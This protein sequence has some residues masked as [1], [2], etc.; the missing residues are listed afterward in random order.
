MKPVKQG[1]TLE[2]AEPET[3]L[4]SSPERWGNELL[5]G[6]VMSAQRHGTYITYR[7][8]SSLP[9]LLYIFN[10]YICL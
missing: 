10:I 6:F 5:R 1:V 9:F 4:H 8:I 2:A 7:M 3:Y